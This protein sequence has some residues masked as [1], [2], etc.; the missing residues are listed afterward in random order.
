MQGDIRLIGRR[1]FKHRIYLSG[2]ASPRAMEGVILELFVV[3]DDFRL[4][5]SLD[6]F[7]TDTKNLRVINLTT[8]QKPCRKQIPI[9]K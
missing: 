1:G 2:P 6:R 8:R 3:I 5:R 7:A 4:E 9:A